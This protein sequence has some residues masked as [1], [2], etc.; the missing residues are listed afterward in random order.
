[1]CARCMQL[2]DMH[3]VLDKP[4]SGVRSETTSDQTE[5]DANASTNECLATLTE[6]SND[7]GLPLW[8]SSLKSIGPEVSS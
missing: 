7:Q 4:D 2:R 1:M 6:Q 3:Q 8:G 5:A